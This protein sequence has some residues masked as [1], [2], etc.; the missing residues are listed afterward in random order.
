M[1]VVAILSLLA[2]SIGSYGQNWT[3]DIFYSDIRPNEELRLHTRYTDIL[4]YVDFD[5][6]YDDFFI[7]IR[8][9]DKIFGTLICNDIHQIASDLNLNRGDIVEMEWMIDSLRPEGD[10]ELLW[11]KEH[12]IKIAKIRDAAENTSW[13]EG[14]VEVVSITVKGMD[15]IQER[16]KHWKTGEFLDEIETRRITIPLLDD[17]LEIREG[18]EF[19]CIVHQLRGSSSYFEIKRQEGKYIIWDIKYDSINEGVESYL[20][21]DFFKG[22][23]KDD[24][25]RIQ[26]WES[27]VRDGG[28]QK[29]LDF[30]NEII[31][32]EFLESPL[33]EIYG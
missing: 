22:S 26:V 31:D 20:K 23:Y 3:D 5:D 8:K 6:N 29:V 10:K 24:E 18:G 33:N 16:R 30:V 28:L 21:N 4:E 17:Q 19:P 32:D 7:S 11:F 1:R 27:F 13:V 25:Q 14:E 12:V 9:G 2:L 15:E